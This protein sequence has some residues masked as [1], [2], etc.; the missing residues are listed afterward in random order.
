[1]LILT[2]YRIKTGNLNP[3]TDPYRK[4]VIYD[5]A[6]L[7]FPFECNNGELLPEKLLASLA[8][9]KG[10][11]L[12]LDLLTQARDSGINSWEVFPLAK[13]FWVS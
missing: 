9:M 11:L 7:N 10:E 6:S 12:Y 8:P 4:E 13:Q 5:S 1:M 2:M 3:H